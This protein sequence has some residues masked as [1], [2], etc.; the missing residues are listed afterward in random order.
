MNEMKRAHVDRENVIERLSY[1]LSNALAEYEKFQQDQNAW[2]FVGSTLEHIQEEMCAFMNRKAQ[3]ECSERTHGGVVPV[4]QKIFVNRM[5]MYAHADV[6]F[7]IADDGQVH[8]YVI[9]NNHIKVSEH[10]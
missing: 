3:Q 7:Y 2:E 1:E 4:V 9:R 10:L 6:L 5:P 8:H